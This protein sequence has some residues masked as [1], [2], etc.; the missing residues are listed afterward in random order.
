MAK[1]LFGTDGIRGVAGAYPLDPSTVYAAGLALGRRLSGGASGSILIGMDTRESGTEIAE[2]LAAGLEDGGLEPHFAGV[3]PT[4]AVSYLTAADDFAA[5]AMISASHNPFEDNGIKVFGANGYK[6]ADDVEHEVEEAIFALL[7][8]KPNPRKRSLTVESELEDRYF[9][10]LLSAGA[11]P[12]KLSP[13]TLLVDCANGAASRLA[14]RFFEALG[15]RATVFASQ[16]D[17][18][19]INLDCGSLHLDR[20]Q[21]RV[22]ESG[23]DLGVAFDGDADRAL[24]VADDGEIVDGDVILLLAGRYLA[25]TDR[26]PGGRVVTTVMANMGLEAAL[27]ESR[28]SMTRTAVG[29]KYVLEEMVESGAEL[30]GEQS[31]HIIFKRWA[32]TGDGLLTARMMLE[33]LTAAGEPLSALRRQLT[34]F[35]QRLVNVTVSSKPPIEEVPVLANAVAQ[36]TE[37]LGDAGRVLVRY[38][39]TEPL[40]RIMIEAKDLAEVDT[41]CER[42]RQVFQAEIGA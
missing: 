27:S 19:N 4:A 41:L 22:R 15:M 24:F 14:E 21:D 26:L 7:D 31:G 28:L 23:A 2:R 32:N 13:K 34:V 17:G 11:E 8:E 20:L 42:L 37:E 10:H 33:V 38:S 35:P 6:L 3:L 36:A 5:G 16:P 1:R 9:D 25:S 39:G 12:S 30:G 40:L 18:R 29:D